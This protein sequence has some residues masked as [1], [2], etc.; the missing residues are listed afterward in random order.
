LKKYATGNGKAE[1]GDMQ[2]KLYKEFGH[3]YGPDECDAFWMAH[4]GYTIRYGS[5]VSYRK[6]LAKGLKDKHLT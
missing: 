4:L 6:E 2:V 3:E 5:D 1:K